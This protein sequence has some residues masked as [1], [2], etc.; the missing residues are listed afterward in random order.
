[1][2]PHHKL[3]RVELI[4]LV[5]TLEAATTAVAHSTAERAEEARTALGDSEERLREILPEVDAMI[6]DG[7]IVMLPVEVMTHRSG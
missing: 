4:E 3:T 5:K 7:M 1:M 2:Q 6:G